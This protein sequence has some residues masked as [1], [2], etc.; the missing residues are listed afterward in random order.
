MIGLNVWIS[1]AILIALDDQS[2]SL[3][4]K[5]KK[6]VSKNCPYFGSCGDAEKAV[7]DLLENMTTVVRIQR[8]NGKVVQDY[9]V[10]IGRRCEQGGWNLPQSKWANPFPVEPPRTSEQQQ[11]A[12]DKYRAWI[13]TQPQLLKDLVELKGKRLGCWCKPLPC[14][15]DV[16]AELANDQN[17]VVVSSHLVAD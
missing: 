2:E 14:H 5:I 7:E 3:S 6:T 1:V 10:Y 13:H 15:G 17:S 11:A 9:D 8:K 12:V 4:T 16:L